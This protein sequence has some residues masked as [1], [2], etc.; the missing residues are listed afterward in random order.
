MRIIKEFGHIK[1][2]VRTILYQIDGMGLLDKSKKSD[3]DALSD[4]LVE[5]RKVGL[6]KW[7]ALSDDARTILGTVPGFYSVEEWIDDDIRRLRNTETDY[8]YPRWH[9]QPHYVEVWIEKDALAGTFQSILEG[10][11][12]LLAVNRGFSSWTF[13]YHNAGRLIEAIEDR[14]EGKPELCHVLYF[15]DM[16][17]AGD[18]IMIHL[19]EMTEYFALEGIDFRKVGVDSPSIKHHFDKMGLK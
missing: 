14:C 9:N 16:D 3:S 18:D 11:E 10:K 1:P 15:G 2:T 17:L 7:N 13:F 4:H 12:V 6:I 5:A 19:A 8:Y